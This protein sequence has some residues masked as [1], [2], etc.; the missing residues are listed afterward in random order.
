MGSHALHRVLD[1]AKVEAVPRS[2][3]VGGQHVGG[4]DL[5][6]RIALADGL[7]N[8][9]EHLEIEGAAQGD[10]KRIVDVG[11]AFPAG[12]PRFD[13]FGNG[14]SRPHVAEVDVGGGAAEGH[15]ARVVLGPKGHGGLLGM[16]HDGVCKMGV[17]I[18]AARHHDETCGIDDPG[19]SGRQHA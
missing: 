2:L 4:E 5:E 13:G 11:L 12:R 1:P 3:G 7:G 6:A 19:R 14:R 15:P 18:D 16:A 17:R 8:V 10:V 9:L